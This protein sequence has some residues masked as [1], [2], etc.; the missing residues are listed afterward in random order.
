MKRKLSDVDRNLTRPLC[1]FSQPWPFSYAWT[2][3]ACAF[4]IRNRQS[5]GFPAWGGPS[6]LCLPLIYRAETTSSLIRFDP[7]L[8]LTLSILISSALDIDL[9]PQIPFGQFSSKFVRV[10]LRSSPN[11]NYTFRENRSIKRIRIEVNSD[12]HFE[13]DVWRH[14][15]RFERSDPSL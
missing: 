14:R 3:R 10:F 6:L 7:N 13:F 8:L 1:G 11:R 5:S 12:G 2:L 4:L 9:L 15:K